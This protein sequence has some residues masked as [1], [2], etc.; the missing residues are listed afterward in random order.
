MCITCYRC[1]ASLRRGELIQDLRQS[2]LDYIGGLLH[3]IWGVAMLLGGI[4][5]LCKG[6]WVKAYRWI[7]RAE[8]VEHDESES[9]MNDINEDD[10]LAIDC[11]D[12]PSLLGEDFALSDG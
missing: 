8:S 6:C 2:I 9:E 5:H 7:S 1:I 3:L 11:E 4:V 12:L 10:A